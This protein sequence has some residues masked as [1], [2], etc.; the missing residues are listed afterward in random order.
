MNQAMLTL[1]SPLCFFL[2]YNYSYIFFSG[3]MA[4][5]YD[6]IDLICFHSI[7]LHTVSVMGGPSCLPV[8]GEK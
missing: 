4:N 2:L 5:S 3:L 6:L 8:F 1:F 7:C